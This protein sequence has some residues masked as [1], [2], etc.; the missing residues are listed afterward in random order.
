MKSLFPCAFGVLLIGCNEPI[1]N[2]K[3][4]TIERANSK[5]A[6]IGSVEIDRDLGITIEDIEKELKESEQEL[7]ELK[8]VRNLPPFENA[9]ESKG[10]KTVARAFIV[11]KQTNGVVSV[12][13]QVYGK[14][15]SDPD[16]YVPHSKNPRYYLV[17]SLMP[18]EGYGIDA[19]G[20]HEERYCIELTDNNRYLVGDGISSL[21][22]MEE[23]KRKLKRDSEQ[24]AP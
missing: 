22:L 10:D 11:A 21:T 19:D 7:A 9:L 17:G 5:E 20:R 16:M 6:T 8:R 13:A 4:A 18:R 1:E 15:P 12:I 3:E 24:A 23:V 2:P 14:V